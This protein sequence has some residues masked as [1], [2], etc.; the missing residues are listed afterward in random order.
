MDAIKFKLDEVYTRCSIYQ[1]VKDLF[2]ADILSHKSCMNRYL[3]QYQRELTDALDEEEDGNQSDV[4]QAFETILEEINLEKNAYSLSECRDKLNEQLKDCQVSNRQLKKMLISEFGQ[5]I[6]FSYPRDKQKS[7]MFF[8]SNVSSK[9]LVE[10]LRS[11]DVI[12]ACTDKL[13]KECEEFNF[14][15]SDTYCDGSDIDLSLKEYDENRPESWTLFFD[16]LFSNRKR[17]EHIKRKCDNIFQTIFNMIHSGRKR[18][19]MHVSLAQTVHDTCRS[20]QLIEILSRMGFTISYSELEKIDNGLAQRIIRRAGDDYVPVPPSMK[21][22]VLIQGAMDNFDHE[23]NTS[24]GIGG[25]HD[26]ILVLFQN[27][28]NANEQN[29]VKSSKA[30]NADNK[31]VKSIL[32]CQK[33][34]HVCRLQGRGQ[35]SA[36][37][38]T[39]NTPD[40]EELILTAKNEY[41]TWCTSRFLTTKNLPEYSSLESPNMPSFAAVNGLLLN[42]RNPPTRVGFPPII[43]FPATEYN[44]IFTCMKN[45]QDVLKQKRVPTGAL[46]CDEGVYRIAKEL[47]LMHA[48][49]RVS[50]YIPLSW[51]ISH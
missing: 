14:G 30:P 34:V 13:K 5:D 16:A 37:F 45:Y 17:S 41:M 15:L 25:T 48:S 50:K 32:N 49:Q 7:Q 43:P 46:W 33:L 42:D 20:K 47:Q 24:S 19:P 10:T 18:T 36:D 35:I 11:T 51:G 31:L 2:A 38:R 21:P 28:Q 29:V 39:A 6:C 1:T 3:I 44:T 9:D 8:S 27:C 23:E 4:K 40:E 12:K 22:S 26:T